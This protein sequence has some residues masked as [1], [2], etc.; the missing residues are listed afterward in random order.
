MT[1][2]ASVGFKTIKQ[3]K[4]DAGNPNSALGQALSS[5]T[6]PEEITKAA[7]KSF[8]E[9]M[10]KHAA[11]RSDFFGAHYSAAAKGAETYADVSARHGKVIGTAAAVGAMAGEAASKMF[12]GTIGHVGKSVFKSISRF[13]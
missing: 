10:K 5:A 7:Y 12:S 9:E 3:I 6:T 13:F 11:T 4:D 8:A 2:D 1:I